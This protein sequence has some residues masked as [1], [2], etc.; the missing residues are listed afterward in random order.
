MEA[1]RPKLRDI[2]LIDEFANINKQASEQ[3]LTLRLIGALAFWLQCPDYRHLHDVLERVYTDIDLVGYFR[4]KPEIE[5]F[6]EA[7]GFREDRL[8][9]SVPGLRRSVFHSLEPRYHVDVFYDEL[10]MCH[11]LDLR[12]RLEIDPQTIP[13]ADLFLEKA[14]IVEINRKDLIDLVMLLLEHPLTEADEEGINL[15]RVFEICEDDWG[16]TKTIMMNL[17]RLIAL[18]NSSAELSPT[19]AEKVRVQANALRARIEAAP[20]SLKW[21]L[22]AKVGERMRWYKQVEEIVE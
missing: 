11:L 13:L 17:D 20:K 6:F 12:N 5:R 22:R 14:Q 21:Q 3:G 19:Q 4:Q 18:T 7:L 10:D 8:L 15:T 9:K 1:V 2:D 16:W